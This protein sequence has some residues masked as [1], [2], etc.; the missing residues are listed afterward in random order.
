VGVVTK[1]SRNTIRVVAICEPGDGNPGGPIP[2][3]GMTHFAPFYRYKID[4]SRCASCAV[5][6]HSPTLA[7]EERM[8][9]SPAPAGDLLNGTRPNRKSRE[10]VDGNISYSATT[11]ERPSLFRIV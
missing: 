9:S 2:T 8:N 11:C 1:K 3:L 10:M 6:C 7:I 5:A 4:D